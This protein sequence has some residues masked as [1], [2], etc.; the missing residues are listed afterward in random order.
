MCA[1]LLCVG[2]DDEMLWLVPTLCQPP[3]PPPVSLPFLLLTHTL[4]VF[5]PAPKSPLIPFTLSADRMTAPQKGA[6]EA[7]QSSRRMAA[8]PASAKRAS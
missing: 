4:I 6:T 2:D 7:D 5:H 3:P 1:L 8:R